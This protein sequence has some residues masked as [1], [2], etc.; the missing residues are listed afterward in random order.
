VKKSTFTNN[1]NI[2]KTPRY[3]D[4]YTRL[5]FSH[6]LYKY[7]W[8]T[9]RFKIYCEEKLDVLVGR[10]VI[11]TV[12]INDC[13]DVVQYYYINLLSMCNHKQK[14]NYIWAFTF[15]QY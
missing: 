2:D 3:R 1:N 10:Y 4:T 14:N 7:R 12:T 15:L 9:I 8:L 13:T 11:S 6:R 5:Q